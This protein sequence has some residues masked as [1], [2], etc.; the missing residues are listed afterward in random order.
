MR[1]RAIFMDRDGTINEE[2]GY[3]SHLSHFRLLP[4]S[5]EA[6]RL[7]NEA[8]F[9]AVVV[10]NQ[11]GVARGHFPES[12]VH[13]VHDKLSGL[14]RAAGSRIDRSAPVASRGPA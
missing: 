13:Q 8:G 4:R 2:V 9:L 3:V 10:T 5:L 1:R 11:S 12:L 14:A 6:I 7:I